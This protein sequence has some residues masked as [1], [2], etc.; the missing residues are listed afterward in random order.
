MGGPDQTYS[1]PRCGA[2]VGR[3]GG[4]MGGDSCSHGGDHTI[5]P[6]S[7]TKPSLVK[8]QCRQ[9]P[10]DSAHSLRA[11]MQRLTA[12]QKPRAL[13]RAAAASRDLA[14]AHGSP[15]EA[16]CGMDRGQVR[17]F[18]RGPK[19]EATS[20]HD[21]LA[22]IALNVESGVLVN[23][24]KSYSNPSVAVDVDP[25]LAAAFLPS[26]SCPSIA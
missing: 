5:E 23:K 12:R 4:R 8:L 15:K 2:M 26:P 14:A 9:T 13:D 21:L 1:A 10:P 17:S 24:E 19:L 6:D 18:R 3:A 20:G 11:I 7:K 22:S 16:I 25:I